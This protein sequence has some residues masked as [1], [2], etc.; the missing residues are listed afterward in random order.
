MGLAK[1]SLPRIW[2]LPSES[3]ATFSIHHIVTPFP[4]KKLDPRNFPYLN[5]P[6]EIAYC[7]LNPI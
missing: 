3:L 4:N 1:E 5:F 2:T 6:L 7:H